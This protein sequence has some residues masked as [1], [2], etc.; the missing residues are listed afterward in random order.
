M[1]SALQWVV[2]AR[3]STPHIAVPY[4][5]GETAD[6]TD[7]LT[8][9]TTAG[10]SAVVESYETIRLSDGRHARVPSA[11][12]NPRTSDTGNAELTLLVPAFLTATHIVLAERHPG[13]LLVDVQRR[14]V[15]VDGKQVLGSWDQW[16]DA[17]PFYVMFAVARILAVNG[18]TFDDLVERGGFT[19]GQVDDAL[20]RLGKRVHRTSIGWESRI[21]GSLVDWSI[22]CY[23]GP[24]GNRTVWH[25][26]LPVQEQADQLIE[27]GCVISGR[28]A[29]EHHSS[30]TAS[31]PAG[32]PY[33]LVAYAPREIDMA[34]LGFTQEDPAY[35]SAE[36]ITPADP[37]IFAT[38]K[39][40]GKNG[41]TDDFITANTLLRADLR[42][43]DDDQALHDLRNRL[44]FLADTGYDLR[45]NLPD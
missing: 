27:A 39:A 37:T 21:V 18:S 9:L 20:A 41:S 26:P 31:S 11:T 7:V 32:M 45:H 16:K 23:P 34:S 29:A 44:Q 30:F 5:L 3:A 10:L 6:L 40:A 24:G 38:A 2:D 4:G 8:V 12:K 35:A 13:I 14:R 19:P 28:W 15:W 33:R 43:H 17:A 36:L 42:T 1:A 25:S 22:A